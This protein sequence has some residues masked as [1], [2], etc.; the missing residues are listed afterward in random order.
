MSAFGPVGEQI[1]HLR[2]EI[3]RS[4]VALADLRGA[5]AHRPVKSTAGSRL[6]TLEKQVRWAE[7]RLRVGTNRTQ[8]L[9]VE[10]GKLS[11]TQR[12]LSGVSA[13]LALSEIGWPRLGR[14]PYSKAEIEH[15]LEQYVADADRLRFERRLADLADFSPG[16]DGPDDYAPIG[17]GWRLDAM[18]RTRNALGERVS[19]PAGGRMDGR[20]LPRGPRSFA[21]SMPPRLDLQWAMR[22]LTPAQAEILFLRAVA[23]LTFEE[24][25]RLR[26]TS[27]QAAHQGY[28][29]ALRELQML[30]NAHPDSAGDRLPDV[31][32]LTTEHAE[33]ALRAKVESGAASALAWERRQIARSE[34]TLPA[35][36]EQLE[37]ARAE[38]AELVAAEE[39]ALA[40]A[41]R[42]LMYLLHPGGIPHDLALA[43]RRRRR[44]LDGV[45]EAESIS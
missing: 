3:R 30:L 31:S 14:S 20:R 16:E 28:R 21:D 42:S 1:E 33:L 26:G 17:W 18:P 36:L 4:R 29:R 45:A 40:R 19:A 10:A 35:L 5:T 8:L 25:G 38:V 41:R 39:Q 32:E 43:L 22:L 13:S 7:R 12:E 23:D 15:A 44:L 2:R 11:A 24:V 34:A 27:T 9:S 6:R 37:Q